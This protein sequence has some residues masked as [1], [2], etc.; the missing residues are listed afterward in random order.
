MAMLK[1][2]L[3]VFLSTPKSSISSK[4]LQPLFV[5]QPKLLIQSGTQNQYLLIEADFPTTVLVKYSRPNVCGDFLTRIK[6]IHVGSLCQALRQYSG[7]VLNEQ[8][9]NKKRATWQRG[10]WRRAA[11]V[12]VLIFERLFTFTTISSSL[13]CSVRRERPS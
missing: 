3:L 13:S 1:A 7:N 6:C 2:L 4:V 12:R 8:S 10:R 11:P 5:T 9:E